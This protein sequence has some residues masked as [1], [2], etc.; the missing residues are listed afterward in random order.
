MPIT[1]E[2]EGW[3]ISQ[4][5]VSSLGLSSIAT[6]P[7]DKD[8]EGADGADKHQPMKP[9]QHAKTSI[10]YRRAHGAVLGTPP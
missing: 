7:L 3:A 6:P 9:H 8:A 2:E 1:P 10:V 4:T 5:L